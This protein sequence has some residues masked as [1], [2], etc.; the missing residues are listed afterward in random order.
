MKTK[1][2][3]TEYGISYLSEAELQNVHGGDKAMRLFGQ[4]CGFVW[5]SFCASMASVAE[6]GYFPMR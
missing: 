3:I 6:Q 2:E 5:E 1:F 4:V